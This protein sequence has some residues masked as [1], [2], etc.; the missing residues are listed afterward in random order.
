VTHR[1]FVWNGLYTRDVEAVKAFNAATV[2]W[3]FEDM[4]MPHQNCTCWLAS[5][6]AKPVAGILDR[7]GIV[8]DT[9]PP[10]WAG[11]IEVD[12]VDQMVAEVQSHADRIGRP[13]FDV[14]NCGLLLSRLT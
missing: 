1:N 14:P 8:A 4:P 5:A 6:G 10:H 2:G 11:H 13:R 7:R 3:T 12:N 9:D